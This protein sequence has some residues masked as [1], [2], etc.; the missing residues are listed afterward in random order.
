MPLGPGGLDAQGV[1]QY[2]EDDTETL[3]SDLL[4]L[5][6]GSVSTQFAIDRARMDS[7]EADARRGIVTLITGTTPSVASGSESFAINSQQA[8][9]QDTTILQSGAA[10]ITAKVAGLYRL[11]LTAVWQSNSTGMR[12]IQIQRNS[13]AFSPPVE[14]RRA[15]DA[16]A[17][18]SLSAVVY[19]AANDV[20]RPRFI[21]T[22]GTG[23]TAEVR[24]SA[25]YIGPGTAPA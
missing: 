22:A 11:N 3:T 18:Q 20:V 24:F 8:T 5:G 19:L 10:I 16:T 12:Q 21:H 7:I 15:A 14:D 25:E 2:G 23:R 6:Q 4:G 17:G 9:N 1:W 13:G